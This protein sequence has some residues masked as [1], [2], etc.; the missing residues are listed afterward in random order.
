MFTNNNTSIA[1]SISNFKEYARF[2][3]PA[4]YKEPLKIDALFCF[5]VV[6][7]GAFSPYFILI[8]SRLTNLDPCYF[9]FEDILAN[10][11]FV[12]IEAIYFSFFAPLLIYFLGTMEMCRVFV[13][14]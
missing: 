12:D 1:A 7:I 4:P 3:Q 13:N 2:Q 8:I 6:P 5:G 14:L 9:I 10:A 11:R